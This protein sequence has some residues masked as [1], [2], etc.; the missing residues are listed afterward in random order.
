VLDYFVWGHVK[1]LIEHRRDGN[2]DEIREAI[3][4]A[5]ITLEMAHRATCNIAR[6]ANF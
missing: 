4:A 5:A 6:R 1:D 2:E 3:F